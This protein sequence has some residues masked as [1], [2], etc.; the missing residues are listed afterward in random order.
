M[1]R[2][3]E[4]RA[5]LA[6]FEA[7]DEAAT[8]LRAARAAFRDRPGDPAAKERAQAAAARLRQVRAAARESRMPVYG[9]QGDAV[10]KPETIAAAAAVREV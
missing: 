8:E 2:A 9:G 7:E 1:S 5:Q 4:L 10:V 6:E 3:D